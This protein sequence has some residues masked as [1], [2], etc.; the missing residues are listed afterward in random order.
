MSKEVKVAIFTILSVVIAIFGS[1]FLLGK[2]ML[3]AD[4]TYYVIFDD[5]SGL[6]KSNLVVING[7]KIGQVTNMEFLKEGKD[8]GKIKTTLSI[9]PEY[10]IPVGSKAVLASEGLMGD[11][12]IKIV[13]GP[14]TG[15]NLENESTIPSGFELGMIDNLGGK[16]T[17]VADNLNVT[18][19]NINQLFDFEKKNVQSLNYTV[20]NLNKL[21]DTYSQ[22]GSSLNAKINELDKTLKNLEQFTGTLNSKGESLGKSLDNVEVLT[23]N[24]KDAEIK[25]TIANLQVATAK[26]NEV[27]AQT[28]STDNTV[29][30]L[31][32]DK[33]LYNN[34]DKA[35]LN[36]N[37]LLKDV[38]LHPKRYVNIQVFGKKNTE[39][40]I[41]KDDE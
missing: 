24:L 3:S 14:N 19:Q 20:E 17:P 8:A 21:I 13:L 27:L 1:R 7:F 40:P 36:L 10:K 12:L 9:D 11:M 26:L 18:L 16:F 2:G 5:A 4:D 37:L 23:T 32:N 28:K 33:A 31:L 6:Y 41:M 39:Q 15:K 34:I 30:A 25:Q 35:I 29:G 22:T 38:R